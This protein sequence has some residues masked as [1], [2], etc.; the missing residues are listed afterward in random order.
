MRCGCNCSESCGSETYKCPVCSKDAVKVTTPL[1]NNLLK[2][3]LKGQMTKDNEY[4]LCM[5]SVCPVSY[6]N[7]KGSPIFRVDDI[8]VSLWYKKVTDKKVACY[9]NNITFEQVREQAIKEGKK[10]WKEIVGAYRKKPMCKCDLLNPTGNCCT[11][12]F[13]DVVNKALAETGKEPVSQEFIDK[14]GCC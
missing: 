7:K 13:Y 6:F 9:C 4:F 3:D 11:A 8:K 14:F 5:D 12:V 10:I 2:N 1:V